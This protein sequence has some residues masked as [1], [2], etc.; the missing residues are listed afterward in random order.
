MRTLQSYERELNNLRE[1]HSILFAHEKWAEI[2]AC[3]DKIID[4]LN[5]ITRHFPH[6]REHSPNLATEKKGGENK[7]D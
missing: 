3:G 6:W 4:L 5:A 2:Q 1:R 7:N